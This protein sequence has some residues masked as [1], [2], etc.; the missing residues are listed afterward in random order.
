[1]ETLG[2][3]LQAAREGKD[4]SFDQASKDT[5]ITVK[6]LQALEQEDF[7][8]FPGEAYVTGFLRNYGSYLDLDVQELLSLY[9]ALKIQEQPIP[10]EQLLKR[11]SQFPKV[12]VAIVVVILVLGLIG[13]GVAL[14]LSRLATPGIVQPQVRQPAQYTMSGDIGEVIERQFYKGDSILVADGDNQLVMELLSLGETL[15]LQTPA[16]PIV[17]NLDQEENIN[18]DNSGSILSIKA[19]DYD[20][21]KEDMGARLHFEIKNAVDGFLAGNGG[22]NTIPAAGTTTPSAIIFSSPNPYPF[23]L[24]ANF[25][26]YCM[27]RWEILMERDRRDRN[28]RYFQRSDE[29]NIQAQ[30]GIRIWTSNAQAAKFQVIGGGRTVP[31]EFG[32]AG[33]VVVTDLRWVRDDDNRFRLIVARLES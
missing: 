15:E 7:S 29:L 27:F 13:G 19:L 20:R 11:P 6:Y 10:V 31:V 23:T 24:Q 25:Q 14:L 4:I 21:N 33:E 18:M 17:L 12:A 1:M 22:G 9:R 32:G 5:K 28:E 26:G 30:N 16:G 2:E 8:G 3:K